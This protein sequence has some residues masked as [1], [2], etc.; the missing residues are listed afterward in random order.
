MHS[1]LETRCI[2]HEM[3]RKRVHHCGVVLVARSTLTVQ[4]LQSCVD[5]NGLSSWVER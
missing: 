3:T 1:F 5:R 2:V 4:R